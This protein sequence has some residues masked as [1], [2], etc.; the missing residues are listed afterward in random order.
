MPLEPDCLHSHQVSLMQ[1]PPANSCGGTS[2]PASTDRTGDTVQPPYPLDM[3]P[4]CP[5]KEGRVLA[6]LTPYCRP[7]P[8]VSVR[9]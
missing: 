4:C 8:I 7:R 3:G 9:Y 1:H 5:V 6:P 2:A